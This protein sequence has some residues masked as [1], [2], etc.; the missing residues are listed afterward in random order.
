M[1]SKLKQKS[2]EEFVKQRE[3]RQWQRNRVKEVLREDNQSQ[4]A[5]C[6]YAQSTAR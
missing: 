4:E 2:I 1:W 6:G 5:I 3:D